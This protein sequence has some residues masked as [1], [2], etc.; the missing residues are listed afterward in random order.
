MAM[1]VG[2]RRRGVMAEIN[3]TPMADVM[4]VL[5]IIFMVMTPLIVNSPVPLPGAR[6]GEERQ[7]A[8]LT[9]V[10]DA[11]GEIWI[12]KDHLVGAALLTERIRGA[13]G[14]QTAPTVLV[15]ADRD[16]EYGGVARVVDACRQAGV[17]QVGL[18]TVKRIGG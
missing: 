17:E 16:A 14:A 13:T 8:Q 5:L 7:P 4:I 2:G 11:N 15:Q 12:G 18:A 6:H 9:V 10:V 1:S 3:V